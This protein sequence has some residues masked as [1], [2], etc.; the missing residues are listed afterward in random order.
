V[1]PKEACH[2][3]IPAAELAPLGVELTPPVLMIAMPEADGLPGPGGW[4]L[5]Y[6]LAWGAALCSLDIE[7]GV[8]GF[9]IRIGRISAQADQ[10]LT[11]RAQG[12]SP[13]VHGA[14]PVDSPL[15]KLGWRVTVCTIKVAIE[16]CA[17][18]HDSVAEAALCTTPWATREAAVSASTASMRTLTP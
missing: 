3:I 8:S 18:S 12:P 10:E 5:G 2:E 11:L 4:I 13:F 1:G 14:A 6:T 16:A 17:L 9:A 15:S 7:E